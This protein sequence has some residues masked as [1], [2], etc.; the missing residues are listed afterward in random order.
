MALEFEARYFLEHKALPNTLYNEGAR[1]LHF[2]LIEK[3]QF[4]LK[5]YERLHA[6]SPE[7]ICPYV[8][9]DFEVSFRTYIRE[10]E[11]CMIL[12][13]EMPSPEQPLLCRAVYLCYGTKG[14]YELYVTSELA[15]DGNYY[16]CAWN[17]AGYHF[18]FGETPADPSD[19]MDM[20]AELFWRSISYVRKNESQG[21]CGSES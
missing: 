7:Y 1:L 16:I 2:F 19:E 6:I 20:A 12:R 17:D 11:T 18:N 5:Q 21:L 14:G 9:S 3:E 10:Q 15:E 4:M 8:A 13:I